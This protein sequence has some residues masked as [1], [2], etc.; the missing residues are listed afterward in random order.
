MNQ[1]FLIT[2]FQDSI[3]FALLLSSP[4][5]LS[6]L[7]S[8]VLISIFQSSVQINEPTFSF[9]P[10][11]ISVFFSFIVFGPWMLQLTLNYIKNIFHIIS[12][13]N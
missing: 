7:L 9:I 12:L 10:K 11:I 4:C 5:L 2:L 8:G 13:I 3:K 6:A 1:E